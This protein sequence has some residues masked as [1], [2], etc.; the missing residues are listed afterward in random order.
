MNKYRL[1][2]IDD[3]ADVLEILHYNLTRE[4]YEVKD[5]LNAVDALQYIT[6]ENTD[7]VITD[8]MLPEMDGLELCKKLKHSPATQAIPVVMVTGRND[9][10]DVVTA[11]ELGAEE[12]IAK[13]FRILE[14]LTRVKKILRRQGNE[15]K[16]VITRGGLK[17]DLLSY[18][19]YV[20]DVLLDLTNA[21]FKLLELLAR[22]PGKVF[23]RSQIIE[24]INGAGY[25]ADKRTID[26][27]VVGLRKK[28]GAYKNALETVRSVGYR[29]NEAVIPGVL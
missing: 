5:F 18:K 17:I 13:P 19:T 3:H 26:V 7:L 27:Q 11:L 22:K 10:I 12:Y 14:L 24:Q 8:W 29:F 9:E 6:G 28:L 15:N 25:F 23:S 4:D 1:V 2:I 16:D 21:E 20:N